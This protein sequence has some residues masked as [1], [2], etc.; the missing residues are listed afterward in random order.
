M[1][2]VTAVLNWVAREKQ[3]KR[4]SSGFEVKMKRGGLTLMVLVRPEKSKAGHKW[5]I[6]TPLKEQ[7]ILPMPL[8]YLI[9]DSSC[10]HV[11]FL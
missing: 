1:L 5:S 3:H 7:H 4:F 11:S 10:F 8:A 2:L 6:S 9:S